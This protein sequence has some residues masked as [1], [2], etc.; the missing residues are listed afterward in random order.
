MMRHFVAHVSRLNYCDRLATGQAIASSV[1]EGA[2]K[3]LGLKLKARGARWKPK[4]ARA[5]IALICLSQSQQWADYWQHAAWP[6]ET[7]STP[8]PAAGVHE[9]VR[10]ETRSIE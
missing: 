1:V 7:A 8:V 5:M 9:A 4:N 10:A 3:T 2:A 6:Q